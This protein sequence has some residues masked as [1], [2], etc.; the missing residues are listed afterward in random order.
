MMGVIHIC[1]KRV[2]K[3]PDNKPAMAA[4]KMIRWNIPFPLN[5]KET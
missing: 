1:W 2:T 3:N 5:D 4:E